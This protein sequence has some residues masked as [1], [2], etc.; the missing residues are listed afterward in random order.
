MLICT[1]PVH[2]S[3]LVAVNLMVAKRGS[4]EKSPD[5]KRE[6]C[7]QSYLREQKSLVPNSNTLAASKVP[8]KCINICNL[9]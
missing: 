2:G 7:E 5:E 4:Q 8:K 3:N 1:L 6:S 9:G